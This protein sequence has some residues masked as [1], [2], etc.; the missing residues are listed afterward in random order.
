MNENYIQGCIY[1]A[2]TRHRLPKSLVAAVVFAESEGN[3][4]SFCYEADFFRQHIERN[5]TIN[6]IAPCSLDSELR[7]R[8]TRWGLMKVN[9]HIAR[10]VGFELPFLSALTDPVVGLEFGCRFLSQCISRFPGK[11]YDALAVYNTSGNPRMVCGQRYVNHDYV[12]RVLL[13]YEQLR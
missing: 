1:A 8:A 4:F 9:G 7:A 5:G 6:A 11:L 3:P 12:K 13:R 10:E 2:A